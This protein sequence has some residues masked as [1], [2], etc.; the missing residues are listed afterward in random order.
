MSDN[1]VQPASAELRPMSIGDILDAT[2]RL[3]RSRFVTFLTI[4]LVAYVPY[5]LIIAFLN[6]QQGGERTFPLQAERRDLG[7]PDINPLGIL[8]TVGGLLLFVLVV[9]PLCQ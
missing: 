7:G 5:A 8:A 9:W 4:A 1:I 6:M 2:F 3:Y